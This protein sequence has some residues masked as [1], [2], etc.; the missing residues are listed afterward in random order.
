[1]SSWTEALPYFPKHELACHGT[2]VIKLDMRFAAALPQLRLAWGGPLTPTSVCRTPEYNKQLNNGKGGHPN[3]LHLTEN[4]KHWTH[5]SMAADLA[6][7]TW[8]DEA[9]LRFARLAWSLG[10]SIGLNDVFIHVDR[11]IDIGLRQQVFNYGKSWAGAFGPDEI[12][13]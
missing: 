4:S 1:M 5:G 8:S 13:R 9:R 11:R 10:W 3:S 2:G 6:W 7:V 12:T